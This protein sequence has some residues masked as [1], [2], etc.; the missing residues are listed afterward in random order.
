M[1]NKLIILVPVIIAASA[2]AI[3]AFPSGSAEAPLNL[4]APRTDSPALLPI[5]AN[6]LDGLGPDNPFGLTE[7]VAQFRDRITKKTFG[8]FITP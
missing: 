3:F 1:Q 7:P 2:A 4:N 8:M 5:S 6:I